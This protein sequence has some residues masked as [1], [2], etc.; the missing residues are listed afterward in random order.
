MRNKIFPIRKCKLESIMLIH[1]YT[2][3]TQ[4]YW[5]WDKCPEALES[6]SSLCS[7]TAEGLSITEMHVLS[8]TRRWLL[9]SLQ[10]MSWLYPALDADRAWVAQLDRTASG[11]FHPLVL[12]QSADTLAGQLGWQHPDA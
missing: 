11:S 12:N 5:T 6:H 2:P 3:Q 7:K 8:V 10:C 1:I 9:T 4:R